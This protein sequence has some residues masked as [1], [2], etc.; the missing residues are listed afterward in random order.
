MAKENERPLEAINMK[1][2]RRPF[3]FGF[4]TVFWFD[5]DDV[6][7]VDIGKFFLRIFIKTKYFKFCRYLGWIW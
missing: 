6:F 4:D 1:F 5:I 7:S 2:R 3:W